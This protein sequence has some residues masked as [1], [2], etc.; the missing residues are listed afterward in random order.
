MPFVK[1]VYH[2]WT[3]KPK[4]HKIKAIFSKIFIN[5]QFIPGWRRSRANLS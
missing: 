2:C 4:F 3:Y 1:L 5:L